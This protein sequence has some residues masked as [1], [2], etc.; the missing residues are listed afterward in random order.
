MGQDKEKT[1]KNM[2]H[3]GGEMKYFSDSIL[4][5]TDPKPDGEE[6]SADIRVLEAEVAALKSNWRGRV[7]AALLAD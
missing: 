7:F 6:G 5:G 3:F 4:N 2:D 1:F